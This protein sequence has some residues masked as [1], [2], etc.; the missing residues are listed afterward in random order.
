MPPNF[1]LLVYGEPG[2]GKTRLCAS[3][4][5]V[6][7]MRKVLI[8]DVDG[9]VRTAQNVFPNVEYLS[10]T[11]WDQ[12]QS[13]YNDLRADASHGFR[14]VVLD[15][16]TE[17]QKINMVGIMKTAAVKATEKGEQRDEEV[18]GLREWGISSEQVRR[19]IRAYRDLPINF[20][21]TAHVKD[22]KDERTQ[23]TR[24]SP[25][26]PGKLARQIAGFFDIVFYMYQREVQRDGTDG[27]KISKTLR[28]LTSTSTDRVTAKDRT[29]R[30]P[31]VTQDLSM[32][33]IYATANGGKS[34]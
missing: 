16:V 26:L 12:L 1:N 15:T 4:D 25:D 32:K 19:M 18:P 11:K 20:L 31:A 33:F 23:I 3:A 2:V 30:L 29:S 14:T 22:D 28:L 24:R 27:Q 8:L 10:V 13:I 17:A 7:E 34:E 5:E 6:A 9:G 21:M